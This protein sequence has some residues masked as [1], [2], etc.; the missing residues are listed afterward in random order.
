MYPINRAG[1]SDATDTRAMG[2]VDRGRGKETALNEAEKEKAL[3]ICTRATSIPRNQRISASL[4][5][6]PRLE[7][8]STDPRIALPISGP[9]VAER[10]AVPRPALPTT[11]TRFSNDRTASP[12]T[13]RAFAPSDASRY[14]EL[15]NETPRSKSRT[16][17]PC[18]H[19][20]RISS[21]LLATCPTAVRNVTLP[22]PP[23]GT[24]A[25][26][27]PTRAAPTL[28]A[29]GSQHS[30]VV[31]QQQSALQEQN[32]GAEYL[33][34][35]NATQTL[36]NASNELLV[37]AGSAE[38][39][40]LGFAENFQALDSNFLP[41]RDLNGVF[42]IKP[43]V[44]LGAVHL[45]IAD[46]ELMS[47]PYPDSHPD[48]VLTVL[49]GWD[50]R[51]ARADFAYR[52]D[53]MDTQKNVE[54]PFLHGMRATVR[55]YRCM[56]AKV[57]RGFDR[58]KKRE[59]HFHVEPKDV[60]MLD[61][62]EATW[63]I[64]DDARKNV[65]TLVTR[66]LARKRFCPAQ[67]R[68][69]ASGAV[70][71]CAGVPKVVYLH[72]H[73]LGKKPFLGCSC[74]APTKPG[75]SRHYASQLSFENEMIQYLSGL[76]SGNASF[77]G[78][79][80]SR[81]NFVQAKMKSKTTCSLNGR[82]LEEITCDSGHLTYTI[83]PLYCE[84][85]PREKKVL[86][87]ACFNGHTHPPPPPPEVTLRKIRL[88]D[89][90]HSQDRTKTVSQLR[91]QVLTYLRTSGGVREGGDEAVCN[92]FF[93]GSFVIPD[94][95]VKRRI[96]ALRPPVS[97]MAS[98]VGALCVMSAEP[99]MPYVRAMRIA[100]GAHVYILGHENLLNH[101]CLAK[102]F[103]GDATY[104]TVTESTRK[105]MEGRWYLYHIVAPASRKHRN[106]SSVVVLRALM[107]SLSKDAYEAVFEYFLQAL[108]EA[109]ERIR[110]DER[111]TG[112]ISVPYIPMP[113]AL[114]KRSVEI[115]SFTTDF[116]SAEALGYCEALSRATGGT[117]DTHMQYG[118]LGCS[119]H[120][121][122]DLRRRSKRANILHESGLS[123][124][125]ALL[126]KYMRYAHAS[127]IEE[128]CAALNEIKVFDEP[129]VNW[130]KRS[131]ME[132]MISKALSKMSTET[133]TLAFTDTNAVE[134]HNRRTNLLVGTH[135]APLELVKDLAKLDANDLA[136]LQ[137]GEFEH[138]AAPRRYRQYRS[139]STLRPSTDRTT[140]TVRRRSSSGVGPVPRRTRQR[141][142][143]SMAAHDGGVRSQSG[144]PSHRGE[145]VAQQAAATGL[146]VPTPCTNP[147]IALLESKLLQILEDIESMPAESVEVREKRTD[148]IL[149]VIGHLHVCGGDLGKA[150]QF[151]FNGVLDAQSDWEFRKHLLKFYREDVVLQVANAS[152]GHMLASNT[153]SEPVGT[154]AELSPINSA[155]DAN[156]DASPDGGVVP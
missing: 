29:T 20:I 139:D 19:G 116:D 2:V 84:N 28:S 24:E 146:Q 32:P 110:G 15:L 85:Y 144:T 131:K 62:M 121:D 1:T 43:T 117:V 114:K 72:G 30:G 12:I 31:A 79:I 126:K 90:F 73:G 54:V 115:C 100:K 108:A 70:S 94:S 77:S 50:H 49:P 58:E 133:R 75:E 51:T 36:I 124:S 74:Y 145:A 3:S 16:A 88:V 128:S 52:F 76:L 89:Y 151:V 69:E 18:K 142:S 59:T 63:S 35:T 80:E 111:G 103:A 33:P 71:P 37:Y 56:G 109:G 93:R 152:E 21:S 22:A 113:D 6:V 112:S 150:K 95:M 147:T 141:R 123:S 127:S 41:V 134:S 81:C 92:A 44:P 119:V 105:L 106:D 132:P 82:P 135:R 23:L 45:M 11:A 86:Y 4:P 140:G 156:H 60:T 101:G 104:K 27:A 83:E 34:S 120:L 148:V 53:T 87:V 136:L 66:I 118:M 7:I 13:T 130:V 125:T 68:D 40:M 91:Q 38:P 102:S 26:S 64:A 39:L 9:H 46:P 14:A 47:I 17:S 65:E 154:N 97:R 42:R 61:A 99:S 25:M 138:L 129:W 143:A 8:P 10:A 107:T 122:R 5:V 48:G 153:V 137:N 149:K 78:S 96:S 67:I 155:P 98:E 55:K 57:C